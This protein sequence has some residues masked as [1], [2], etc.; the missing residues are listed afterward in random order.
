[1]KRIVL[2]AH[3][4]GD[5][6]LRRNLAKH[7]FCLHDGNVAHAHRVGAG[8]RFGVQ[9]LLVGRLY[10]PL[11]PRVGNPADSTWL[12]PGFVDIMGLGLVHELA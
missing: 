10:C 12:V 9:S 8:V 2:A 1:M 5:V 4:V 6:L 3:H 11:A 7:T